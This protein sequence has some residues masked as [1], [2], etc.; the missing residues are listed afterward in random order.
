MVAIELAE[1]RQ[2][3]IVGIQLAEGGGVFRGDFQHV[4]KA[5]LPFRQAERVIFCI[6]VAVIFGDAEAGQ[7]D[8]FLAIDSPDQAAGEM[9]HQRMV[10]EEQAELFGGPAAAQA[11]R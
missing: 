4:R 5:D 3:F 6:A 2:L 10:D 1:R 7:Q 9:A 8:V 11:H